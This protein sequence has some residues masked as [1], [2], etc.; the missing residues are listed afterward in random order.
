M[1]QAIASLKRSI[2]LS[3]KQFL[4]DTYYTTSQAGRN[5]KRR[6][7][8]DRMVVVIASANRVGSTWLYQLVSS[9]GHFDIG[10]DQL[11]SEYQD[12]GCVVLENAAAFAHIRSF[13]GYVIFKTHSYPAPD[14]LAKGVK[15]ITIHRDPRDVIT[16]NIFSL[17]YLRKWKIDWGG[18]FRKL[19]EQEQIRTFIREADYCVAKLE[20]WYRDPNSY[21]V[22][23]EDLQRRPAETLSGVARFLGLR[24]SD[25]FIRRVITRHSFER[26]SGRKPGQEQKDSP[27]R[28]GIINDW[29]NYFDQESVEVFK[30]AHGGR[31]NRLLLEMGYEKTLDWE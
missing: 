18:D 8:N 25:R 23:Y 3:S 15:F 5:F 16:S 20:Q 10:Y 22:C 6:M 7:L 1:Q 4:A 27:M 24:V 19:S 26:N 21:K 11:A 17:T 29:R 13:P 12:D 31:W 30:T 9:L 28:K 14:D 2:R